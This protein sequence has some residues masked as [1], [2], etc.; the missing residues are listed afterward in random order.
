MA[1]LCLSKNDILF[2]SV[3][4]AHLSMRLSDPFKISGAAWSSSL[5]SDE[6]KTIYPHCA[7][8]PGHEIVLRSEVRV[9]REKESVM[10]PATNLP[11][12]CQLGGNFFA[13]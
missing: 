1:A 8:N 9:R 3:L 2:S 13:N 5:M 11:E 10:A 6:V 4:V 12:F 7:I